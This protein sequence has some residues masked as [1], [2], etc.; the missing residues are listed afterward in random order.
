MQE[1]K[2]LPFWSFYVI[3]ISST[4]LLFFYLKIK[5]TIKKILIIVYQKSIL[6]NSF[7][8]SILLL[9]I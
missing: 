4:C 3:A 5:D 2:I 8:T 1:E 7:L 6:N 9:I